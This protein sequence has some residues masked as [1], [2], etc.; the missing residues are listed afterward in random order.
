MTLR[1]MLLVLVLTIAIFALAVLFL[2][3]VQPSACTGIA[4][5]TTSHLAPVGFAVN[6][7]LPLRYRCDTSVGLPIRSCPLSR[8]SGSGSCNTIA[9]R[10]MAGI[11]PRDG[12][13]EQGVDFDWRAAVSSPAGQGHR[14]IG[15]F[16]AARTA[17]IHAAAVD[18]APAVKPDR[19]GGGDWPDSV[20]NW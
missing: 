17:G 8:A 13:D 3:R 7:I 20:L 15:H 2:S 14:P 6:S 10:D 18:P 9:C 5:A 1:T 12:I 19:G 16:H 11:G 4:S